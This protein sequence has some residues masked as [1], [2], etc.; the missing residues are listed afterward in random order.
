MRNGFTLHLDMCKK[1]CCRIADLAV[2]KNVHIAEAITNDLFPDFLRRHFGAGISICIC[3]TE[4]SNLSA[5]KGLIDARAHLVQ[6]DFALCDHI[7]SGLMPHDLVRRKFRMVCTDKYAVAR[8]VAAR[9]ERFPVLAAERQIISGKKRHAQAA[10]FGEVLRL[11]HFL[12]LV[13]HKIDA[14]ID[15]ASADAKAR[16]AYFFSIIERSCFAVCEVSPFLPA[17]ISSCAFFHAS[18][19]SAGIRTVI[20]F[21]AVA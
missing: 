5:G 8:N 11:A 10:L 7:M 17:L 12:R 16:S 13:L 19:F 9:L 20:P 1:K 3:R 21:A 15:R 6:I 2:G 14:V 4:G 18:Y